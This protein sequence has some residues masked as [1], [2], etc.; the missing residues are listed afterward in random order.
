[1]KLISIV[2]PMYNEEAMV[3]IFFEHIDKVLS[4]LS[5]RYNFEIVAVNDGSKDQTL[6]ILKDRKSTR[7]NSS[8]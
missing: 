3:A 5:E 8:H 7:L 4:D 1:M 2:V 6:A